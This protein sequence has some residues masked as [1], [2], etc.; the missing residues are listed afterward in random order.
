MRY[1]A[2]EMA[3]P[4]KSIPTLVFDEMWHPFYVFQYFAV[5]VWLV[6]AY[7]TFSA[8]ILAI[9]WFSI[10]TNA[11]EAHRNME[12]LARIAHYACRVDVCR[13]GRVLQVGPG[14]DRRRR[15]RPPSLL[16]P[17]R[18]VEPVPLRTLTPAPG[19]HGTA[20]RLPPGGLERAGA[21][22][23]GAAGRRR[24][25]LR[26]GAA[27][28]RVHRGREH[29]DG[30]ERASAQGAQ[31]RRGCARPA[32]APG[33]ARCPGRRS[34]GGRGGSQTRQQAARSPRPA[35]GRWP[36]PRRRTGWRTRPTRRPPARCTAA[37]P[38]RRRA[39]GAGSARWRW[40][41]ARASTA[42]RARCCAP[43]SSPASSARAL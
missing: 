40:S 4:V 17:V 38:W 37:P 12:R 21:G 22:G 16:G 13:G 8:V 11:L 6:E 9:T 18:C 29:A 14:R 36:T 3:I 43:S 32:A 27:Q 20:R 5:L 1:G 10:I 15:R 24:A 34:W 35:P 42:P 26:H 39:A 30:R 28:R 31:R 19:S 25:A 23:R 33:A 2:N 7:F 41:A